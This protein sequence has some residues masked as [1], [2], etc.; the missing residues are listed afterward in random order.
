MVAVITLQSQLIKKWIALCSFPVNFLIELLPGLHDVIF[1]TAIAVT[2][3]V[4]RN[5][6]IIVRH[7]YIIKRNEMLLS[8]SY[9][10][11]YSM[12]VY[13]TPF[14]H[15]HKAGDCVDVENLI[16]GCTR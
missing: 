9:D 5:V 13:V 4:T 6:I 16:S 7:Y 14:N 2:A 3:R 1:K 12:I 11:Q 8:F 15:H 10:Y